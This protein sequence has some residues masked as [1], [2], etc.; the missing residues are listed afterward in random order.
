MAFNNGEKMAR[1]RPA[2]RIRRNL[3][4][5]RRKW[6]NGESE[7]RLAKPKASEADRL[8]NITFGN[9]M[10]NNVAYLAN[11]GCGGILTIAAMKMTKWR[12]SNQAYPYQQRPMACSSN[13]ESG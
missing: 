10:R 7:K 11:G 13:G 4:L 1:W 9:E 5:R 3:Y 6:R 2:M 12:I 8:L